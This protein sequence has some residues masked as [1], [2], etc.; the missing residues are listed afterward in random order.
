MAIH[1]HQER[2]AIYR[3]YAQ[4]QKGLLEWNQ[5]W[6]RSGRQSERTGTQFDLEG[7]IKLVA[8]EPGPPPE[9]GVAT[10]A[11]PP[12]ERGPGALVT[13]EELLLETVRR[14][15]PSVAV[16]RAVAARYQALS[17]RSEST[18]RPS[19]KFV[20]FDYM[21]VAAGND[22]HAF[23]A[24]LAFEIPFGIESRADT[25]RYR[26]LQRSEALEGE[27]LVQE[28][29]RRSLFALRKFEHFEANTHRWQE[30]LELARDAEQVADRWR[31]ERLARPSQVENLIDRA[32]DARG[33]VLEARERA[34][35]ARC[36]VLALTGVSLDDWPRE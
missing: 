29:V 21:P 23:G 31:D 7:R 27:R 5:E 25:S 15:H 26:A 3:Q 24:Q 36:T 11:L 34:G 1:A 17:A 16:Y 2:S 28:Q 18:G 32:Y 8:R 22:D 13:S 35:L 19:L 12:V 9:S 6:L 33:A 30:L 20:D 10:D 4:R 14:Q